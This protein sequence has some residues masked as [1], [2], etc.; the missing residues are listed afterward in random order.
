MS[1]RF[2]I[3]EME[4]NELNHRIKKIRVFLPKD[5]ET[6]TKKYPVF[7]MHDGQNLIDPSPHSGYSWD[8]V[9]T[10]DKLQ[11]EKVT[12]GIIVVGIDADIEKR[13]HEYSHAFTEK[14]KKQIAIWTKKEGIAEGKM[15][16]D[17]LVKELKPLIDKTYRTKPERKYTATIGSSCGGNISLYLGVQYDDYFSTIGAFSPAYWFVKDD[18]FSLYEAKD[19]NKPMKIYHDMGM[20]EGSFPRLTFLRDVKRFHR[21]LLGKEFDNQSL[22]VVIDKDATHTELFWQVRFFDFVKWVYNK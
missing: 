4:S 14:A 7:Y 9:S 21:I 19:F 1:E 18:L 6:T 15:Y 22:S 20:K 12:A 11:K 16:A 17:F 13:M 3:F 10:L 5:Y 8:V 2:K